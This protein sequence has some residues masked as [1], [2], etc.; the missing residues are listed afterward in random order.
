MTFPLE[1]FFETSGEAK[2]F[3]RKL[4]DPSK[5]L[6]VFEGPGGNGKTTLL[7][8]NLVMAPHNH[9]AVVRDLDD[10]AKLSIDN[11]SVAAKIIIVANTFDPTKVPSGIS[12]DVVHFPRTFGSVPVFLSKA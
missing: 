10:T 7:N 1:S 11:D 2:E 6:I 12:Y 8:Q 4:H 9:Y 5:H 3:Y